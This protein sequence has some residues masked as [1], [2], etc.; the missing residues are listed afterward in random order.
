MTVVSTNAIRVENISE[1]LRDQP[2]WV[3]W[4]FEQESG[5]VVKPPFNPRTGQKAQSDDPSTWG[6]FDEACQALADGHYDG[7]GIQLPAPFVGVELDGCRDPETGVINDGAQAI[8]DD[9]D[10]YTEISPSGR[11]VHILV[12]EELPPGGNKT[13]G[14]E[15]YDHD[16]F[17]VTGQHLAGTPLTVETRSAEL[18][19][20]QAQQS[21]NRAPHDESLEAEPEASPTHASSPKGFLGTSKE[22]NMR[23]LHRDLNG[24]LWCISGQVGTGPVATHPAGNLERAMQVFLGWLVEARGGEVELAE[25][26]E[27]RQD[28]PELTVMDAEELLEIL[29]RG[30]LRRTGIGS[31]RTVSVNVNRFETPSFGI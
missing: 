15:V 10:S 9:L 8:I 26:Q 31:T 30:P 29:G 6:S 22:T 18:D 1:E 4:R 16:H 5:R 21:G 12:K 19:A 3:V 20:L 14:V 11:G 23:K 2:C 28:A 25:F 13:V 7:I 27:V 17:S 24:E